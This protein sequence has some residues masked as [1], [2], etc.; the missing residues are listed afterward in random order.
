MPEAHEDFIG[1]IYTTVVE[2]KV[3]IFAMD[4]NMGMV[5]LLNCLRSRGL[6]VDVAAYFPWQLPT[7][8]HVLD[9]CCI[10]FINKPGVYQLEEGIRDAHGRGETGLYCTKPPQ[11]DEETMN[12]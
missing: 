2:Y 4:A 6:T 11:L 8:E 9:S 1:F 5:K 12:A 10:L 3:D 7:G